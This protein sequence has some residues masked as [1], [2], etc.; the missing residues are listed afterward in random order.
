MLAMG[1][2][3]VVL[4]AGLCLVCGVF[5]GQLGVGQDH[6]RKTEAPSKKTPSSSQPSGAQILTAY[7]VAVYNSL[8]WDR[9]TWLGVHAQ[10][11]PNDV[12][13]YQ[14]IFF[15]T[16][17]D[18]V[19]EAGTNNGGGALLWA[20]LLGPINPTAKVLTIDIEDKL[21]AAQGPT[22]QRKSGVSPRQLD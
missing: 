6:E 12:W 4:V 13:S 8:L 18:F 19:I 2:K 17:P 21:A 14:E 5:V 7:H 20:T 3:R 10:Q 16:K 15:E 1:T 9:M 22:F 11:N